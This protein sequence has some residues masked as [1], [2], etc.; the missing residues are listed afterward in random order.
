M[1]S[2][3][4]DRPAY[5]NGNLRD[6]LCL[7]WQYDISGFVGSIKCVGHTG[8]YNVHLSRV[9]VQESEREREKKGEKIGSR[10]ISTF[11]RSQ[12]PVLFWFPKKMAISICHDYSLFKI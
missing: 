11:D 1:M 8:A 4:C 12:T 2:R 3:Q 9:Q 6:M 10:Y 7:V 5:I